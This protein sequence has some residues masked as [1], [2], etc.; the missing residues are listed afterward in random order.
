MVE[1][2]HQVDVEDNEIGKVERNYAHKNK[3][4]HRSGGVFVLNSKKEIFITKRNSSKT[5]FPNCFDLSCAFHVKFEQSYAEAAIAELFEENEIK[6][7]KED[8][9][10]LG[11]FLLDENPD[12]LVG[13]VYKIIFDGKVIA[14]PD[15]LSEGKFCSFEEVEEIIANKKTTMWLRKSWELFKDELC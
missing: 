1:Y 14:T 10:Y 7:K 3:I 6:A 15:E 11:K 8:L 12:H 9:I 2:L 4:L 5:I 13:S